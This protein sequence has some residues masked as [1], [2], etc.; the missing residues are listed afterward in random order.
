M[1]Q[2]RFLRLSDIYLVGIPD[3]LLAWSQEPSSLED[4]HLCRMS[5]VNFIGEYHRHRQT[6]LI[7]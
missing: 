6:A 5:I 3:R 1:T 2:L 4:D 7:L